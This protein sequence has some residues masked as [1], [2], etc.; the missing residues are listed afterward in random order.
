MG[1]NL[2]NEAR[3]LWRQTSTVAKPVVDKATK[4][5]SGVVAKGSA[6][7]A[8]ALDSH[9][10]VR[11]DQ[12][13]A[14]MR[15]IAPERHNPVQK[16]VFNLL[17]QV[18]RTGNGF[19]AAQEKFVKDAGARAVQ[20]AGTLPVVGGVARKVVDHQVRNFAML[21][22]FSQG[23]IKG[24]G[25]NVGG[26][27]AAA[28]TPQE[29][30]LGLVDLAAHLPVPGNPVR[31][32]QEVFRARQA[33]GDVRAAVAYALDPNQAIKD[34]GAFFQAVGKGLISNYRESWQKGRYAEALGRLTLDVVSVVG[35][36][37]GGAATKSAKTLD[38]VSD[39][40]TVG[41]KLLGVADD[42]A[43]QAAGL[44]GSA[45]DALGS[46]N[47]VDDFVYGASDRLQN[48]TGVGDKV[49]NRDNEG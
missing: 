44:A 30:A 12:Q 31:L 47:K 49:A 23:V 39:V 35:T 41:H 16:T 15:D 14:R 26:L 42:G 37:G 11:K 33:G 34:D 36:G 2:L 24:V 10:Q 6:A 9:A 5:V 43:R 29:I 19:L 32:A 28:A 8:S 3:W 21:N 17:D 7:R 46:V 1:I 45:D 25:S 38:V 48:A 20:L 27:V 40:A 4:T 22:E 13:Q 18:G